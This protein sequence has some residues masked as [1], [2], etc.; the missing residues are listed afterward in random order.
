ML[1]L[2]ELNAMIYIQPTLSYRFLELEFIRLMKQNWVS[3][4]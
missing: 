4:P 1:K 2:T 3:R